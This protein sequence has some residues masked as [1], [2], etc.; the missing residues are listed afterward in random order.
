MRMQPHGWSELHPFAGHIGVFRQ[1]VE[2]R[3][4]SL[5]VALSLIDAEIC[6]TSHVDVDDVLIGLPC[7]FVAH[8]RRAASACLRAASSTS[9]MERS[10][11]PLSK[12]SVISL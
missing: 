7:C 12:P 11:M 1:P 10:L 6:R 2:N 4:Q 9:P 3:S 5:V 8:W